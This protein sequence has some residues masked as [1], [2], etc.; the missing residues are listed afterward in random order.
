MMQACG[1][2]KVKT[3]LFIIYYL[4]LYLIQTTTMKTLLE[5]TSLTVPSIVTS[6]Y[7]YKKEDTSKELYKVL[8]QE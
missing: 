5:M 8:E 2:Q 7:L 6:Q 4:V 1:K 3:K